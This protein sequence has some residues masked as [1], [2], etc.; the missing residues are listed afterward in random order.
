VDNEVIGRTESIFNSANIFLRL[1]VL[2]VL[3]TAWF[4]A[5]ENVPRAYLASAIFLII[6]MIL[7][8]RFGVQ[9]TDEGQRTR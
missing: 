5:G 8:W 3:G 1:I 9:Q 6:T 4:S 2:S 7:L